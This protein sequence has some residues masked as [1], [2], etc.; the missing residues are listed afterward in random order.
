MSGTAK[1]LW[2]VRHIKIW[3]INYSVTKCIL[4][5]VKVSEKKNEMKLRWLHFVLTSVR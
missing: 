1:L 3:S 2:D 5:E 4:G